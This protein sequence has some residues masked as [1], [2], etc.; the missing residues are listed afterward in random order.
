MIQNTVNTLAE[1]EQ[2]VST[3]TFPL[4][5]LPSSLQH[6]FRQLQYS[7]K[8]SSELIANILL[9]ALSLACQSLIEVKN[10]FTLRAEPCALYLMTLAES[11]MG[12]TTIKNL[13]MTPFYEFATAIKQDYKVKL[14][15]YKDE[16]EVWKTVQLAL[17]SRLR[18]AIKK[19]GN[20]ED[21]QTELKLHSLK[22]PREPLNPDTIYNDVSP[23]ALAEGLSRYSSAALMTDE[24]ITLLN[25]DLKNHLGF[26]N[27]AWDSNIFNYNRGN[28]KSC[29]FTPLLTL[30]LM[31]QPDIFF[32]YLKK[33]GA[34]AKASGF[35]S[36]F[37]FASV[38]PQNH[39]VDYRHRFHVTSQFP[40]ENALPE[41]HDSIKTLLAAQKV[42]IDSGNMDKVQL[43]LD[44]Q[45]KA[46]WTMKREYWV[47]MALPQQPWSCIS[48]MVQKANSNTLRVA[49]MLHYFCNNDSNIITLETIK[50]ATCIME[51]YIK[52]AVSLFCKFTPE[53]QF[54]LDTQELLVWIR[55]RIELN[56][57]TPIKKN[58]VLKNGPNRLR[59]SGILEPLLNSLAIKNQICCVQARKNSPIYISVLHESGFIIPPPDMLP[60]EQFIILP[61]HPFASPAG[62]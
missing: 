16:L 41:F 60:H 30:L 17:R 8:A 9:S 48:D 33:H 18:T 20:G 10:P 46:F 31:V 14:A 52:H 55:E 62:F 58:Y 4:N 26:L 40:G 44:D 5:A 56:N 23:A 53:Y 61:P 25:N 45:A 39:T 29:S 42:Q 19:G 37:L 51:W 1:L 15:A 7:N 59:N 47:N 6:V 50:Q 3:S 22:A 28:N 36:R 2:Q 54:E 27:T 13:V 57:R 24:A 32:D 49:G 38:P 12:K 11:G 34:T 35:L 43:S 21:E